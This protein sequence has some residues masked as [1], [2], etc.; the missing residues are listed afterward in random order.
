[1]TPFFP[2]A[3]TSCEGVAPGTSTRMGPDPP[4]SVSLLSRAAQFDGRKLSAAVPPYVGPAVN[5]STASPWPH[6][7]GALKPPGPPNVF[8]VA[9]KIDVPS[10]ASPPG[11]Q[12]P[13]PR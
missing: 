3:T 12:M 5:L 4:R 10:D 8:P 9:A 6:V 13:P 2:N 7:A 11:P 1:M